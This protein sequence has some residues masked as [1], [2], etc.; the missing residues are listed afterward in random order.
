MS[1]VFNDCPWCGAHEYNLEVAKHH[2]IDDRYCVACMKCGMS[3]PRMYTTPAA[4]VSWNK[5]PR[6][7]TPPGKE[8]E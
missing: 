8:E 6:T 1:E 4:I 3:G 2:C 5:L 7:E